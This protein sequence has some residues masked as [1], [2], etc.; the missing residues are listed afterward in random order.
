MKLKL[1]VASLALQQIK[2]VGMVA[3][4]EHVSIEQDIECTRRIQWYTIIMLT[5]SILGIII[6]VILKLKNLKLL[7]GHLFSNTVK[8][9][10]FISNV[11]YYKIV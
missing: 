2:E 7:R 5:I 9:M 11:Q 8:I 1:L 6:F 3:K 4:Q 10:L